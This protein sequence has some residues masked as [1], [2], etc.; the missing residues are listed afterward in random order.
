MIDFNLLM[1]SRFPLRKEEHIL[2]FDANQTHDFRTINSKCAVYLHYN[3]LLGR[4]GLTHNTN[5]PLGNRKASLSALDNQGHSAPASDRQE[6]SPYFELVRRGH[7][8]M[9]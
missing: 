7:A 6:Q 9:P 5:L 1:F 3:R 2:W 4:R 8:K